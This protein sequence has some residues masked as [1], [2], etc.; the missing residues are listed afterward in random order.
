MKIVSLERKCN[1]EFTKIIMRKLIIYRI[2]FGL[3]LKITVG[4][5]FLC[6]LSEV[7]HQEVSYRQGVMHWWFTVH[8]II[9]RFNVHAT[10]YITHSDSIFSVW[11]SKYMFWMYLYFVVQEGSGDIDSIS[12]YFS[13]KR[14]KQRK[15]TI[16]ETRLKLVWVIQPLNCNTWKCNTW[17]GSTP[18]KWYLS[19][20]LSLPW[21]LHLQHVQT[22]S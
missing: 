3:I 11:L 19:L 12:P 5:K 4:I 13:V 8:A 6:G 14:R 21:I 15:R 10:V 20:W 22:A 1:R 2:F 7:D 17:K 9:E 16:I 18:S